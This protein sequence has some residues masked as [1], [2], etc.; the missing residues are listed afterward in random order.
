[1]VAGTVGRTRREG[2]GSMALKSA[3]KILL[4]MLTHAGTALAQSA[5]T[6]NIR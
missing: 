6:G 2:A 4:F 3:G 1:M 5:A